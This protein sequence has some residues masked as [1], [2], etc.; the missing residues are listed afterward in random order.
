ME[1]P[2]AR[3]VVTRT[4]SPARDIWRRY[5]IE[6][7][8]ERIGTLK[9]GRSLRVEISPGPHTVQALIDFEGSHPVEFDAAPGEEICLVVEPGDHPMHTFG[10]ATA[11]DPYLLLRLKGA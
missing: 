2:A 8:G 7:D 3:L 9:R 11:R 6:V 4:S 5:R 10:A 1:S